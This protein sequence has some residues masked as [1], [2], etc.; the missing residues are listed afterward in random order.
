MGGDMIADN[1]SVIHRL[2]K[3]LVRPV[4]KDV[5]TKARLHL[6]D[7]MGCVAGARQSAVATAARSAEADSLIRAALLGNLL[8]MDDVHRAALLHPGPVAWPAALLAA[9]ETGSDMNALLDA[10]VRGYDVMIAIGATFDAHHYAHF[11]TTSTAGGFGAV[12]AAGSLYGLDANGLTS[13]LGNAGSVAGGLWHMR[14]DAVMTKQLHVAHAVRTGTW[15]ARLAKGGLTGPAFVLEGPQGLYAATTTAPRD[16]ILGDV[17]RILEVSFKPFAACRHAHPAID[18]ALTLRDRG[19]LVAPFH[20]DTYADA[21][22]FCDRPQPVTEVDAKFS[23]QHAIAVIADGGDAGPADFTPDAIA[24]HAATRAQVTVAEDTAF[25][26]RYPE[27][28]GARLTAGGGTVELVDT[29]G[30]PERPASDA[31]IVGK[32]RTLMAWGGLTETQADRAVDAALTG[33]DPA[34]IL[35]LLDE[36]L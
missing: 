36:W 14:H 29:L 9:R 13:A 6:L 17:S 22:T 16:L 8:E 24:R 20:V 1:H 7:W 19:E 21:L 27:H 12:A 15:I 10:G 4:D 35:A 26:G 31:Q 11:H 34:A 18:C 2:A 5:R 25:T 23:L 30:D 32:A 28:F 33:D 3:H